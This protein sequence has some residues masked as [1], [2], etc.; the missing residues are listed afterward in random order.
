MTTGRA[1]ITTLFLISGVVLSGCGDS[2]DE[3]LVAPPV[4]PTEP[5]VPPVANEAVDFTAFVG[6]QFTMTA[7]DTDP[8]AVDDIDFEFNDEDDPEAFDDLLDGS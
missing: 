2:R 5:T 1:A 3:V 7:E 6:E 4:E 8:Q